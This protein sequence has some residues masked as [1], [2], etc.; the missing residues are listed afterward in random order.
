MS[1]A[2]RKKIVCTGKFYEVDQGETSL[3]ITSI[4]FTAFLKRTKTDFVE[5]SLSFSSDVYLS[6]SRWGG[7]SHFLEKTLKFLDLFFLPLEILEK[8][9]L[10]SWKFRKLV[11]PLV[12]PKPETNIS[13]NSAW[14][15]LDHPLEIPFLFLIKPWKCHKLFLQYHGNSLLSNTPLFAF[16]LN[17]SLEILPLSKVSEWVMMIKKGHYIW[18]LFYKST[19]LRS[20]DSLEWFVPFNEL[21]TIPNFAALF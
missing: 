9:K 21:S 11:T 14:F 1:G 19:S 3:W 18:F 4:F 16:F 12:F 8:P 10:H 17:S 6:Y 2:L 15:F 20:L 7:R 13:Q 5:E